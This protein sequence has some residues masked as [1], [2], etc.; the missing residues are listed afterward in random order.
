MIIKA[1]Q[2][3]GANKLATHLLNS[4]DNEHVAVHELRG[5]VS[6]D[7]P[8][9]LQE[10]YAISKATKCRQFLFSVSL[11]PPP[12][13]DAD[14]A[15]FEDVCGRI[16]QR[17]GLVDQ[18]RAIVFHEKEGRRHAHACWSRIDNE[19]MKAVNM[20]YFKNKMMEISKE[21]YLEQGWDLP[22]GFKDREQRNPLNFTREQWQQAKRLQQDPRNIKTDFKECWATAKNKDA[23]EKLLERKGYYLAQGDRRG[24]VAVDWQGETYSLSRW[25]GE[26][27]KALR[28][29]LG[30]ETKLNGADETKARV[31]TDLSNSV[32]KLN[33]N[34]KQKQQQS[35]KPL[36]ERKTAMQQLH[37]QQREQLREDQ[38]KHLQQMREQQQRRIRTGIRG[39]L[40]RLTGKR[41]Q[42]E[43]Q[44]QQENEI[45]QSKSRDEKD[46]LIHEQNRHRRS[47][48]DEIAARRE[49]HN[50]ERQAL[51]DDVF[52]HVGEK[53]KKLI[54]EKLAQAEMP[55]RAAASKEREQGDQSI[56][57]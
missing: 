16:E 29:R 31:D 11:N 30:D 50:L 13:V 4:N 26:K 51:R 8:G 18:P 47:L 38:Y 12:K 43:A 49:Q 57:F 53:Q 56:S 54:E 35:M 48:Q 27:T 20:S 23:F 45:N 40:D 3:G 22:N 1:S 42:I 46:Q 25:T 14:T 2:R 21:V 6:D 24:F 9:A 32:Q 41:K 55:E 5:Y 28:E 17:A 52:R 19:S 36:T 34:L 37:D 33:D 39:W 7:L 44:N 15:L 10:S